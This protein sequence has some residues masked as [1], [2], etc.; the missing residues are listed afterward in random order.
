MRHKIIN[1]WTQERIINSIEKY[2][3]PS[4][5]CFDETGG[6]CIYRDNNGKHCAI[7]ALLRTFLKGDHE[8]FDRE[9]AVMGVIGGSPL[10]PEFMDKLPLEPAGLEAYQRMHDNY[11]G[12]SIQEHLIYWVK[13]NTF[14]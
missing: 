4:G 12:N 14:E 1:G 9:G 5:P 8:A 10:F 11:C 13:E 2:V 6:T 3:P 7:G